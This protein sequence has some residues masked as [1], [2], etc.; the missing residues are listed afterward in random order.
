MEGCACWLLGWGNIQACPREGFGGFL[1]R[2]NWEL[3]W[4]LGDGVRHGGQARDRAGGQTLLKHSPRDCWLHQ[5]L[6]AAVYSNNCRFW[7]SL[8]GLCT[9]EG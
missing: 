4:D 5:A 2:G 8:T 3:G 9:K 7:E 6:T 1:E